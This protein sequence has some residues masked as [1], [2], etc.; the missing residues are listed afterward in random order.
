MQK[1]GKIWISY[2]IILLLINHSSNAQSLK[3]L[4]PSNRVNI[5]TVESPDLRECF[6]FD[7]YKLLLKMRED[8]DYY[9]KRSSLLD[10]KLILQDNIIVQQ[11]TVIKSQNDIMKVMEDKSERLYNMWTVENQK[12]LQAENTPKFGG[13]LGWIAASVLGATTLF[14]FGYVIA[15]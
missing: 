4:P 5:G 1:I 9:S 15:N 11:D 8:L 14:L 12:R 10:D 3:E 13:W 2:S 6:N 7:N